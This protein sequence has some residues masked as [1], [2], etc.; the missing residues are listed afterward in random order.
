L[1]IELRIIER[2]RRNLTFEGSGTRYE[3]MIKQFRDL[4]FGI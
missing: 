2:T 4:T 1:W 3:N